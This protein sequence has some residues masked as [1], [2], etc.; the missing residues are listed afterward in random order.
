[1][2]EIT[3]LKITQTSQ[4]YY[5]L[6]NKNKNIKI[7]IN[8]VLCPFGIDDQYG[9]SIIKFE[10][11]QTN[12]KHLEVICKIKD[13]ESKMIEQLKA[14][15]EEWK[16]I[17]NTRDNNNIFIEARIKKIKN[18]LLTK[19]TFEDNETNYLKTIYELKNNFYSN[20]VLEIPTLWDFRKKEENES[21]KIGLLINLFSIHV[22]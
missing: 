9:H 17:I 12:D 16:G 8:N 6:K 11:D 5:N 13:F 10:L 22:L 19:L 2:D 21:N 14:N 1:M 3:S 18:N 15:D 4:N 7:K 20:I